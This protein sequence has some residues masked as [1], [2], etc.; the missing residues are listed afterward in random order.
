MSLMRYHP[1]PENGER[2][3]NLNRGREDLTRKRGPS[4]LSLRLK[5]D[6]NFGQTIKVGLRRRGSAEVMPHSVASIFRRSVRRK[7][8]V[9]TT[10]KLATA[11][12]ET[13]R[14]NSGTLERD[15]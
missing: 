10:R 9:S 7:G 11:N 2:E 1:S 13:L 6:G 3:G 15:L 4:F 14:R 5:R 12:N 8:G